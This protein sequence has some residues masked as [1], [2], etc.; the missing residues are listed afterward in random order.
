MPCVKYPERDTWSWFETVTQL[1]CQA[2]LFATGIIP[3]CGILVS[4]KA[5]EEISL[6][7]V[8]TDY[9]LVFSEMRF[10][11]I[12]TMLGYDPVP[13]PVCSRPLTWKINP[14]FDL[15]YKGLH[16]PRK[17]LGV[18]NLLK[19]IEPFLTDHKMSFPKIIHQ[20]WKNDTLNENA[21][22]LSQTWRDL[23]PDWD[24]ILWTDEMNRD[25]I[26]TYFPEFLL[27]YDSY[28]H[29]IQ[30]VDAVR[31]FILYQLGGLFID[32]DFECLKNIEPLLSE[33]QCVFGMEPAEHC[34]EHDKPMIICNAFMASKPKDNFLLT[35][36]Q[37]LS[38][39]GSTGRNFIDGILSAA[40]PFALTPIYDQYPLK[41]QI[42]LLPSNTLYPL[43]I[44]E[45]RSTMPQNIEHKTADAY[46]IHYFSGSWYDQ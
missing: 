8:K 44:S 13:N 3:F 38:F 16:Y 40:G 20:T 24:Y 28:E 7:I 26:A 14:P 5:M 1:P 43:T 36:C 29:N 17:R 31:Y 9:H 39:T 42:K 10:A 27:Q 30:R 18:G 37:S 2:R 19:S 32:L 46:A 34:K 4:A 33:D 45:M 22:R 11:T 23:H 15:K 25:F 12:A 35:I 21:R 41:H 6:E